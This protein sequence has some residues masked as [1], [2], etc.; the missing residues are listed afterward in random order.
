MCDC[1]LCSF[2]CVRG[3]QRLT[4]GIF[5]GLSPPYVLKQCFLWW[6]GMA[7]QWALGAS[8]WFLSV[9][10]HSS[11]VVSGDSNQGPQA[12]VA[13]WVSPSWISAFY[14]CCCCCFLFN[15]Y[16]F[17]TMKVSKNL[18]WWC[19]PIIW[20]PRRLREENSQSPKPGLH[21]TILSDKKPNHKPHQKS[22]S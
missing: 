7:G 12:H 17:S 9:T 11:S 1:L 20:T 15:F 21:V 19:I 22:C 4:S 5:L 18:V 6:A 8:F 16:L 2:V 13:I 3:G 14:Y 10:M